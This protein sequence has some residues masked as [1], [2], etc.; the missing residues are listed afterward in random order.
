ML[1]EIRDSTKVAL[2]DKVRKHDYGK[3]LLRA[4]LHRVRGF[5]GEEISFDFPVTALIGPNGSGK[6]AVLGSAGCAYK[7]VRPGAFFPKSAIGDQSMSGWRIEYDIIDKASNPRQTIKRSANFRQAKWV[8]GEVAD[9]EVLFFGI[10]RTVPAGEKTRF[11]YLMRSSYRHS[12]PLE[13]LPHNVAEQAEHILG[14]S[15]AKYQITPYGDETFL[16]GNS[17][18][19]EYSEFHFGAGESSII[20]MVTKIEAAENNSLVLIEE[21][22]NGLH[23]VATRRM[24]EYLIDVAQRKSIQAIFT[25]HSDSALIP[26]PN[27]GIWACID[28]KLRQ[29]KLSVEALRAVSGRVDKKLAIFVEDQFAKYWVEAIL[30]E[31]LGAS[32][33]Q[34]EVHAVHGD[35]NAVKTHLG[36]QSNPA[37]SFQSLCIIDGD[38][39]QADSEEYGII[40]LPGAM[41][42]MEVFDCVLK[43]LDSDIAILTVSCQRGPEKQDE[44]KKA[45]DVVSSTNRD[46]HLIFNQ[47]GIHAGFTPE[48]IV[49]GAFLAIWVRKNPEFCSGLANR[50]KEAIE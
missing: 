31:Y 33:E 42:E 35:G 37:L 4:S 49:R 43:D 11:R 41:P 29:G 6:S 25:T 8:R 40:R 10:E 47:I 12:E 21:I 28:G 22:E 23:P 2:A 32:I 19:S 36:H 48:A 15:V 5:T 7:V 50:V 34:V 16:V 20:R 38:S 26:L 1:S 39:R 18:S 44:V 27:E 24:V 9:R 30:R 13:L 46:P 3:Y 14:K 45:V 17:G